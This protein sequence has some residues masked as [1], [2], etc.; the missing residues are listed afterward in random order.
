VET[1]TVNIGPI[2]HSLAMLIRLAEPMYQNTFVRH[3]L[4]LE[5]ELSAFWIL[6]MVKEIAQGSPQ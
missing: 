4:K 3:F 5:M 6:N 2:T 1:V